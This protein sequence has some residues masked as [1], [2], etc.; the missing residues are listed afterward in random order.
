[1]N[2]AVDG[3]LTNV[4]PALFRAWHPVAHR[5]E[6][7]TA[8]IQVMLVGRLWTLR[9]VSGRA[10]ADPAPYGLCE[11]WGLVWLAPG[12]PVVELFDDPDE[13]DSRDAGAWLAPVRVPVPASTIVERLL[14]GAGD[15]A[16][17]RDEPY[18]FRGVQVGPRYRVS[19]VY[20]APFHLLLGRADLD[21]AAVRTLLCFVQPEHLTSSRIF[22]KLLLRG[23]DGLSRP[24][25]AVLAH[26]IAEH[27]A[28]LAEDLARTRAGCLGPAR[29]RA[30]HHLVDLARS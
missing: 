20:R 1:M 5:D 25:A 29:R 27:E 30:L 12:P 24:S 14:A 9:R 28:A 6:V 16:Q 2:V 8:P 18:G 19:Y 13:A 15:A 23:R 21:S 17:V 10:V 7:G 4:D 11:R 22:T 26:E 3:E